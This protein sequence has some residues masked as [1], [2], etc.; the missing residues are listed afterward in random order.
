VI[1]FGANSHL[2]P[3]KAR[4]WTI[5]LDYAPE[6]PDGVRASTTYYNIN[7]KDR[8]ENLQGEFNLVNAFGLESVLGPSVLA[9]NPSQALVNQYT[10]IPEF[11]N[12]FGINPTATGA[13]LDLRTRNLAVVDTSGVDIDVSYKTKQAIGDIETGIVASRALVF[14]NQI[15]SEAPGTSLLNTSYNPLKWKVRGR[16]VFVRGDLMTALFLNYQNSYQD[17][18]TNPPAGVASWATVD[19]IARYACRGCTGIVDGLETMLGVRNIAN[20]APP[21]VENAGGFGINFDG[22][23]GNVLGRYISFEIRKKW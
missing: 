7:Y 12:P 9:R 15:T 17:P 14:S 19:L 8:I 23:N 13:L 6:R 3:E 22:A 16:A 1:I 5:G 10:T 20:R 2:T 18:G 11:Q 21:F 4:T